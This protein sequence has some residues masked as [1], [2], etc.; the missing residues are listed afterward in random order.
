MNQLDKLARRNRPI[1]ACLLQPGDAELTERQAEICFDNGADIL[2]VSLPNQHPYLD[3]PVVADS[4]LRA[5]AAG[6]TQRRMELELCLLR[7]RV[8][9]AALVLMGYRNLRLADV[10]NRQ[11]AYQYLDGILQIGNSTFPRLGDSISSGRHEIRR[12]GFVSDRLNAR[13]I[14]SAKRAGG[15]VMLQAAGGKTGVRRSFDK[16][17]ARKIARLREAGIT[18]PVL[19]GFGISTPGHARPGGF[20]PPRS[21]SIS[22]SAGIR[23][24]RPATRL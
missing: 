24:R 18:I 9:K 8:P 20:R 17:N 15:Y 1:L 13:E 2:E 23:R 11:Q 22:N 19:L 12:I 5:L 6:M 16:S 4:M 7:E 10:Q 21:A 3:G 14:T